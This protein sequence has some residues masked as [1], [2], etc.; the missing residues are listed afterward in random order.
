MFMVDIAV[1]RDIE[2]EVAKLD[3]VYL[4]TIDDLQNVINENIES[5]REAARDASALIAA[6]IA[7]FET[8]LKT[9]D[10]APAIRNMRHAA[11][12]LRLQT[13]GQARRMLE[14]G[15]DPREVID[16]LSTTL[17]NRLMHGPSQRLRDAAEHG[18]A[19]AFRALTAVFAPDSNK[20]TDAATAA[21]ELKEN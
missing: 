7:Q 21:S 5:R 17:T 12:T 13:V 10:A 18:D 8:Q 1:P 14:S 6:E 4:F 19:E 20:T 9:L 16:F 15:R 2:P 3:D 11:D